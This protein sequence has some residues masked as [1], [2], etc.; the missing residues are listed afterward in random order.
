MLL[1]ARI[2]GR[3]EYHGDITAEDAWPAIIT[4]D[5]SDQLR[6]LLTRPERRSNGGKVA[7]KYLLS[8]ILRCQICGAGMVGRKHEG[9][10]RYICAK[11]PGTDHC[12]RVAV[13]ADRADAEVRDQILTTLDSPRLARLVKAATGGD[14]DAAAVTAKLR[15]VEERREELATEWAAG[16]ISRKEWFRRPG[17]GARRGGASA[18]RRDRPARRPT[19]VRRRGAWW[20]PPRRGS[21][22]GSR[23]APPPRRPG[24]PG[25]GPCRSTR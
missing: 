6:A 16:Q 11:V 18:S 19:G 3:R 15:A 5:Q 12:G 14:P 8:G 20:S 23:R 9:R 22:P 10:P 13:Y 2:S 4:P 25:L 7:R 17:P 21:P 24:R 1:S